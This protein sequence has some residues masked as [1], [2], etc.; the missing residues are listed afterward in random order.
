VTTIVVAT[1]VLTAAIR[2]LVP[3]I[4]GPWLVLVVAC[5]V[6]AAVSFVEARAVSVDLALRGLTSA[7]LAFGFA[8]VW[9]W[10][11]SLVQPVSIDA[12]TVQ[13]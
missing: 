3:R 11:A 7:A 1:L 9:Q 8:N 10:A 4:D 13:K 5:V 12:R 2:K 6:G